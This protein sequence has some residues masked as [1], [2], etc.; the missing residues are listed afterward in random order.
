RILRPAPPTPSV[1]VSRGLARIGAGRLDPLMGA[2]PRPGRWRLPTMMPAGWVTTSW[3]GLARKAPSGPGGG[4][5]EPVHMRRRAEFRGLVA[6][7]QAECE[8]NGITV[9]QAAAED[10]LADRVKNMAAALG[11]REDTIVRSHLSTIDPAEL[12]AAFRL[13]RAE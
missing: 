11:V 6:R 2:R 5:K 3:A 1:E 8:A 10:L 4:G 7:L 12:V 9:S 13:A